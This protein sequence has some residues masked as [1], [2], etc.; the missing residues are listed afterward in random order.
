MVQ[1]A[2]RI[3]FLDQKYLF[4]EIFFLSEID[5]F[6]P[7]PLNGSFL[8][9]FLAEFGGK[10]TPLSSI[11]RLLLILPSFLG[12]YRLVENTFDWACLWL[13]TRVVSKVQSL[14]VQVTLHSLW[15]L[16]S[17]LPLP[18]LSLYGLKFGAYARI[19]FQNNKQNIPLGPS[20][21]M[22]VE[23]IICTCSSGL[24]PLLLIEIMDSLTET[25]WT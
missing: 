16:T 12:F 25:L 21:T 3:E 22:E 9:F 15:T 6:S 23:K 5:G 17:I 18:F 1:K 13:V 4:L 24:L 7:P 14:F 19:F 10:K 8:S 20:S 11:W 2:L